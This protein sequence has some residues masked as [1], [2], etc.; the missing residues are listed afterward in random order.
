MVARQSLS[1]G[2]AAP[3]PTGDLLHPASEPDGPLLARRVSSGVWRAGLL[4]QLGALLLCGLFFHLMLEL[5]LERLLVLAGWLSPLLAA[6]AG[7]WALGLRRLLRPLHLLERLTAA[8]EG[9]PAAP[10][11]PAPPHPV[12]LPAPQE[13]DAAYRAAHELPYRAMG[14]TFLLW[15]VLE[16]ALGLLGGF[17]FQ[18]TAFRWAG[19]IFGAFVISF[20]MNVYQLIGQRLALRPCLE[21]LS[22]RLAGRGRSGPFDPAR[23]RVR[24]PLRFKLILGS[25]ALVF[26]ACAFSLFITF[27]Q[28]H[29]LI[30]RLQGASSKE[31]VKL[32]LPMVRQGEAIELGP[33]EGLALL[34]PE[35][36]VL[37]RWGKLP[38]EKVLRQLATSAE[39]SFL[40]TARGVMGAVLAASPC[41]IA[42]QGGRLVLVVPRP[43]VATRS[44]RLLILFMSLM[45]LGAAGLVQLSSAEITGPIQTLS[46]RAREMASGRLDR[47]VPVG[48]ADEIGVLSGAV[49]TMRTSLKDKLETIEEL[50]ATLEQKVLLRTRELEQAMAQLQASEAKLV[51]SEKMA[52]LGQLVAGVAHEINN[53]VNFVLNT[54]EPLQE[55]VQDLV[56]VLDELAG[57]RPDEARQLLRQ[58]GLEQAE[59]D[60]LRM[61]Q[62]MRNGAERTRRIVT[63]LRNFSRLDEA[64]LKEVRLEEGIDSTLSLLRPSIP[65]GVRI[66]TAYGLNEPVLCYAG[67]LNQIFMNLLKNAVQAVGKQGRIQVATAR[68]GPWASVTVQDDGPGIPEAVRRRIFDPFFTTKEVGQGTGLGLSISL[69]IAARHG[70]EL[71]CE[72][73]EGKGARFTL[74]IPVRGPEGK[75]GG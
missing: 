23:L 74:R 39:G 11:R 29:E 12:A 8:P 47:P 41:S 56:A 13:L 31:R 28:S 71:S 26:F 42:P 51:Q 58:R 63:D 35:G 17:Y 72:S 69:G 32:L 68:E 15:L 6:L 73:E 4:A 37:G 46:E 30:D 50:N 24:Y 52:S 14:G 34:A 7:A 40:L 61:L 1:S 25:L 19:M 38:D 20:G 45:F 16:A 57:G 65:P 2:G 27:L 18:E 55:L 75:G 44:L 49:E 59:E 21:L 62:V 54:L 36:E 5:E 33:E 22:T 48:E 53:P 9:E 64:E 60:A 67:Q 3:G 43:P 10:S 66:E 70:G